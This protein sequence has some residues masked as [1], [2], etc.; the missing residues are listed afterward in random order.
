MELVVLSAMPRQVLAA[1]QRVIK[2]GD[3]VEFVAAI[4]LL[5]IAKKTLAQ[6]EGLVRDAVARGK[7]L[8]LE[9]GRQAAN[10]EYAA[11]LAHAEAARHV[12]MHHLKPVLVDVVMQAVEL[13]V[14]GVDRTHLMA[15]ALE[16]VDMLLHQARWARLK[17]HPSAVEAARAAVAQRAEAGGAALTLV[18]VVADK[19]LGEDGCLFET[20]VGMA[21]GS[22]SVQLAALR[23]AVE[24][25]VV[26]LSDT[27]APHG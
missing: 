16:S 27:G 3:T 10:A 24:A 20:D 11:R 19:S 21:D 5:S 9:T 2:G 17:V 1:S 6:Q 23:S 12:A 25:A 22:L 14:H 8:G 7:A 18:S 4:D 15:K 26:S 13:V